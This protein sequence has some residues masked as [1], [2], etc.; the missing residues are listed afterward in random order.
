MFVPR[1]GNDK[2]RF[3]INFFPDDIKCKKD[4]KKINKDNKKL[5]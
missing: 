1:I 4:K 2:I 5:K 3:G